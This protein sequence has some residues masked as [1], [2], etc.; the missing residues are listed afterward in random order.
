MFCAYILDQAVVIVL[1]VKD[2]ILK[3]INP[4]SG[5]GNVGHLVWHIYT[6]LY[7]LIPYGSYGTHYNRRFNKHDLQNKFSY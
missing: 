2:V 3:G 1:D 5:L 6:D 4:K 7:F